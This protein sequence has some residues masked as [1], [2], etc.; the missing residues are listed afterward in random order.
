MLLSCDDVKEPAESRTAV[1]LEEGAGGT[2]RPP[3]TL[4]KMDSAVGIAQLWTGKCQKLVP[5]SFYRPRPPTNPGSQTFWG[6]CHAKLEMPLRPINSE[7]GRLTAH[8]STTVDPDNQGT[9]YCYVL[10]IVP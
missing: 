1:P 9:K 6:I 4:P 2:E 7:R 3:P 8:K 5:A 10:P